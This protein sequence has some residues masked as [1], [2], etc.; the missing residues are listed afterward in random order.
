M[1]GASQ[2]NKGKKRTKGQKEIHQDNIATLDYYKKVILIGNGLNIVFRLVLSNYD[3]SFGC[4]AGWLLINIALAVSYYTMS[5]MSTPVFEGNTLADA[6]F[7]LNMG[8]GM[9][10]HLKDIILLTAIVQVSSAIWFYC[11]FLWLL[12]PARALYLLWVNILSPFFFA[13]A[14]E[15]NIDPKKQKKLERKAKRYQAAR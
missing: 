11:W 7:D 14:P 9:G 4:I 13:P 10:E 1:S 12:L 6:G 8:S 5:S 15:E 3:S 2:A